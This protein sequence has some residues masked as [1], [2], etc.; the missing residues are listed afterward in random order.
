LNCIQ[1]K[2]KRT[3]EPRIFVYMDKSTGMPKGEC[4]VTYD[5]PPSARAAI[6]WFNSKWKK[7]T[8]FFG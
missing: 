6:D 2:D 1:Q 3:Q 5:D 4:T 8:K 7:K